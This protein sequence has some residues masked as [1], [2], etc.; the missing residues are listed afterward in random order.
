VWKGLRAMK[1]TQS[2]N[3]NQWPDLILTSDGK[4]VTPFMPALWRLY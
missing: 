3:D 1:K 4:G 2:T